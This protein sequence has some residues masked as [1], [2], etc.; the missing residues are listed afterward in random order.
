MVT[1][2]H[3]P[4]RDRVHWLQRDLVADVGVTHLAVGVYPLTTSRCNAPIPP[5]HVTQDLPLRVSS[6]DFHISRVAPRVALGLAPHFRDVRLT[7][8]RH[9]LIEATR[10]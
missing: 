7:K 6:V 9:F 3:D 2:E 5:R 8:G 1:N 10:R 4:K